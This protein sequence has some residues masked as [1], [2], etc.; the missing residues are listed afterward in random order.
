MLSEY[1]I[2]I[3]DVVIPFPDR[4][5]ETPHKIANNFETEAG[6]RVQLEVRNCRLSVSGEWTVSHRWLK[7]F[8]QYRDLNA[9]TIRMY[10]AVTGDYKSHV[11]SITEDSFR[12]SL[13]DGSKRVKN[14][15]GLWRVSFEAEEF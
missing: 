9:I 15:E 10:D 1:P 14:T 13:I 12:Y 7:K 5:E 3:N 4:W 8:M 6:G 2:K 11:M